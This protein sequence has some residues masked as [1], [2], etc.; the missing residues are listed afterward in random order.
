MPVPRSITVTAFTASLVILASCSDTPDAEASGLWSA[1]PDRIGPVSAATPFSQDALG[2]A[3]GG[4]TVTPGQASAEGE[5]YL[6]YEARRAA[7]GPAEVIID[8]DGDQ[9]LAVT[10]RV[11]GLLRSAPDVGMSAGAGELDPGNCFPGVEE[12]SGDIVCLDPRPTGLTYWI[13]VEH[14]GPDGEMPPMETLMA[15]TVYEIQWV[16]VPA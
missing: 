4:F 11:P 16:P 15:G 14:G 5:T 8:G 9:L 3:L 6:V 7:A 10:I 2:A 1:N 13:R 12:R